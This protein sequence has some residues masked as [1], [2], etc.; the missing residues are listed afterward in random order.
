M[1]NEIR[2]LEIRRD[3]KIIEVT[4]EY[5]RVRE[6]PFIDRTRR[7]GIPRERWFAKEEYQ[8]ILENEIPVNKI[9]TANYERGK[10]KIL[11]MK[12]V[13]GLFEKPEEYEIKLLAYEAELIIEV[14]NRLKKGEDPIILAKEYSQTFIGY[15]EEIPEAD[16]IVSIEGDY[17][18][19]ENGEI[20][21][22][23]NYRYIVPYV[24]SLFGRLSEIYTE[25]IPISEISNVKMEVKVKSS[26]S[27]EYHVKITLKNGKTKNI[28]FYKWKD[29][30]ETFINTIDKILTS[31]K[32]YKEKEEKIRYEI[33]YKPIYE[34][35]GVKRVTSDIRSI[36]A[37]TLI[38]FL[39]L[40]TLA[41]Q[42]IDRDLT[43]MILILILSMILGAIWKKIRG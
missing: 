31:L 23:I 6:G 30:A 43:T 12:R 28:N 34:E 29:K 19:I 13:E 8:L 40:A 21:R 25:R 11:W 9:V 5:L 27:N 41:S 1:V 16:I 26:G 37:P 32:K 36:A 17:V 42:Y 3:D 20:N 39:I 33:Q 7:M 18:K 35:E 14:L 10:L 22:I 15:R 38:I 2:I 24:A 4:S